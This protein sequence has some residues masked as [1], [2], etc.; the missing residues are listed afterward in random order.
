[1][2]ADFLAQA[3]VTIVGLGLMGG[4]LA[5]ALS[6]AGACRKIVGVA[7][8]QVT[9]ATARM[10]R[11]ID[12]GTEDLKA[13]VQEADLV[14]LA[15][16]VRDI[17]EKIETI[18]PWLKPDAVL[19]DV[20]STKGAI[21]QAMRHLPAHVQPVGAHPMCGK[22][23][24]G[25]TMAEPDLYR[26]R[27]FVLVPLERTSARAFDL[28]RELVLAVGARPLVLDA[29]QH[30]G[31]V[32]AISHLPYLLAVTLV[33]AAEQLDQG[34]G[35][36]WELAAG[37]FRDTSRV[38]AGSIPMMLD[39]LATNR[40]PILKALH[41]AQSQLAE[42]ESLLRVEDLQSLRLILEAARR[43]RKEVYQ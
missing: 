39:I 20:G 40:M 24:S 29:Q 8:R 34:D 28:A 19:M 16:P 2:E 21:C 30:D 26:D 17:L 3:Q 14:V 36:M 1:M 9:L 7:R 43:R 5:A 11:F 42:I 6:T 13:G 31:L 15:T 12:E 41:Q 4:S 32:A 25:L 35:L 10:L 33:A 18:G 37:G 22:E 38:A 27:T 23:S